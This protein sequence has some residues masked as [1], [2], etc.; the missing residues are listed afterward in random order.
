MGVYSCDGDELKTVFRR[1]C[2]Y[3]QFIGSFSTLKVILYGCLTYLYNC[4]LQDSSAVCGQETLPHS[5]RSFEEGMATIVSNTQSPVSIVVN[6][7]PVI[8]TQLTPSAC[9]SVLVPAVAQQNC[10]ITKTEY[11]DK[12]LSHGS[13]DTSKIRHMYQGYRKN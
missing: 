2:V 13:T 5:A 8:V 1:G 9:L 3:V 12:K 4:L 11:H 7:T 10:V 6:T